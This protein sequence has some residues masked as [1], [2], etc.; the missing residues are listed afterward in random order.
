MTKFNVYKTLH[1]T[2]IWSGISDM[3][4]NEKWIGSWFQSRMRNIRFKFTGISLS[5]R[6]LN[7]LTFTSHGF[8][9]MFRFVSHLRCQFLHIRCTAHFPKH[10][11]SPD[12]FGLWTKMVKTQSV[13]SLTFRF[14]LT[15]TF[16][17]FT[18]YV[19]IKFLILRLL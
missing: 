9:K 14:F 4:S 2:R 10:I 11:F 7:Y 12:D 17:G 13:F 18:I 15:V 16:I 3:L 19:G 8:R 1:L 6:N 5:R